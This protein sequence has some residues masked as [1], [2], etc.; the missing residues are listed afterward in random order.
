MLM[1]F[2]ITYGEI[3]FFCSQ[4]GNQM[5]VNASATCAAESFITMGP[6]MTYSS[7]TQQPQTCTNS[8]EQQQKH[9][10]M[11]HQQPIASTARS[12]NEMDILQVRFK[13]NLVS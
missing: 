8:E 3:N 10:T 6:F 12:G 13:I 2:V 1:L 5:D 9:N 11:Y 4:L 7:H